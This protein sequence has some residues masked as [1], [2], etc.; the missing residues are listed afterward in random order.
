[1]QGFPWQGEVYTRGRRIGG[2]PGHQKVM[3]QVIARV[4][5]FG[6][7]ITGKVR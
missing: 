7:L 5:V 4:A 1:M 6:L 3:R 2:L